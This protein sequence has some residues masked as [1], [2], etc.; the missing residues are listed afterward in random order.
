MKNEQKFSR[1]VKLRIP[2]KQ[3]NI[4]INAAVKRIENECYVTHED[5]IKE[6]EF[7][8]SYNFFREL[9]S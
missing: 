2:R 6:L 7:L 5:V 9:K 4:E 1:R 8:I 3:Y